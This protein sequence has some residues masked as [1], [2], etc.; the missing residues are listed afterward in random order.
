M[1]Y[2]CIRRKCKVREGTCDECNVRKERKGVCIYLKAKLKGKVYYF[3]GQ[4]AREIEQERNQ[5]FWKG[6][7]DD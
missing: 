5:R 3:G 2:S 6:R 1:P 7:Q 4:A